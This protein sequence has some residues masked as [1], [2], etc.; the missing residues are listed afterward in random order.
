[1]KKTVVIGL[2]GT[3][4]DM[5]TGSG[6]WERW[7][8]TVDICR[9]EDLVVD[10]F[11]LL[12]ARRFNKLAEQLTADITSV[13]PETTVRT[14]AVEFRDPWDFQEVYTALHDF[15]RQY[16][17][18]PEKENYLIHITT[19]THVAQICLFLLTESH[20]FP[21][22][23]IQT[24]PPGSHN[25]GQPGSYSI[26]DLD[27]S[28]YDAIAS[29][30]HQ[31]TRESLSFLK[32]G[33][34]TKNAAF[35]QL[36]ERIERVAVASKA[37]LLL[38]GPTGSGKSLLARRIYE[39][40]K[41]RRQIQGHFVEVNCAT[42]RGDAAMSTLFGHM[43]GAFTGALQNRPGLLRA[44][45]G[46]I[47]FLDEIGELGTDE[48]AMLLRTLEDKV[49]LPLGSD[50][51]SSSNFQLIA[52]TN[53]DLSKEVA[54]GNFREDLF[55]RINLWIFRLPPLRERKEDLEPNIRYELDQF[56]QRENTNVTFNKE[57]REKFL[58]FAKSPAALW[59]GNFR[60][61]SGSL[62]RMATLATTT[63]ARITL[64]LVEQE[65]HHLQSLWHDA[66]T[67]SGREADG[68]GVLEKFLSRT[69]LQTLDRFDR[70]Q[71]ADV[72]RV[73]QES[74]TLSDAGRTLFAASRHSRKTPNDADR[75]RKYLARFNLA[76]Q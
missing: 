47:L 28:K 34:D 42:I 72:L 27:L 32:S 7:R 30:F 76:W 8:P 29:R 36:I 4:L 39:L 69:Q 75:L 11:E 62:Q 51:E 64:D 40:K 60:D 71:L 44:A 43:K 22:R 24:A 13:S 3:V 66:A 21:A 55:A 31:E 19:G 70:V 59:T 68:D 10:R 67:A 18:N 14:H 6:R 49:F 33:I 38:M 26:I 25:K 63:G 1:M 52:G 56:A 12:C 9:H 58:T 48:Q 54:A 23:L 2:I 53:R 5:G 73:C 45:D 46:G 61:L 35:N 74:S 65:I 41:S 15:A 20:Y 16:P 57:A 17:F 50:K 37:P